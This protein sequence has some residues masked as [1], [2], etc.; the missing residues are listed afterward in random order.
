M[1]E[2]IAAPEV[3]LFSVVVPEVTLSE[4]VAP[5]VDANVEANVDASVDANVV[6]NVNV[7]VETERFGV[8]GAGGRMGAFFEATSAQNEVVYV[9]KGTK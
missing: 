8:D 7:D 4:G 9:A 6:A 5:E 2:D 3:A 1:T